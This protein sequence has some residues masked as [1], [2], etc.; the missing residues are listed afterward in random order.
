MTTLK[1]TSIKIR[2]YTLFLFGFILHSAPG[3]CQLPSFGWSR[4]GGDTTYDQGR[5]IVTDK[6]RN[7]IVT[8]MFEQHNA[9]FSGTILNASGQHDVLLLKYAPDGSLLWA[10]RAGGTDGDV[11]HA[12]AVDTSDNIFVAGEFETQSEFGSYTVDTYGSGENDGFVAKYDKYGNVMWVRQIG[13]TGDDKGYGIVTDDKGFAYTTGFMCGNVNYINQYTLSGF[14][15]EDIY[16]AGYDTYGNCAWAK[17]FGGTAN[18]RGNTI[19]YNG[20]NY[21]YVSGYFSGT[22]SFDSI[23]LTSN[24]GFDLFLAKI[25]IFTGDVQWVKNYGGASDEM[26]ARL[27][28]DNNGFIYAA[29]S[30]K[31]TFTF[32]AQTL[33]PVWN[34]DIMLLKF[35]E[36][37]VAVWAQQAGGG[38]AD[39]G[40]GVVSDDFGNVYLC[41]DYGGY[42]N[43]GNGTVLSNHGM[44]DLFIASY[45]SDG[46]LQW[47][48]GEGGSS[49][50]LARSVCVTPEGVPYA[51]GIFKDTVS[52]SGVQKITYGKEDLW[53]SKIVLPTAPVP[54]VSSS[55]L[56]V[57]PLNCDGITVN[58]T[59]GNGEKRMVIAHMDNP[60]N[61]FPQNGVTYSASDVW[62]LGSNLG[63]K[64]HVLYIGTGNSLVLTGLM[65]GMEYYF[66]VVEFNGSSLMTNYSLA[67]LP[68]ANGMMDAVELIAYSDNE[69]ICAGASTT[70]HAM[71]ASNFDWTSSTGGHYSGAD[72]V[73]SPLVSTTYK[74]VATRGMCIDSIEIMIEVN[75]VAPTVTLT[76]QDALC[77]SICTGSAEVVAT[78]TGPF[79]YDWIDMGVNTPDISG[80]CPGNYTV[81]VTDNNGCFNSATAIIAGVS[82][83]VS[84]LKTD[85]ACI[86]QCNGTATA[87]AAGSGTLSYLWSTGATT[88]GISGL[89]SGNY[90][91]TVTSTSGCQAQDQVIIQALTS[92]TAT[93]TSSEAACAGICNGTAVANISNATA[94]F[95]YA[96]SNGFAQSSQGGLCEGNYSVVI[97]DAN[98]CHASSSVSIISAPSMALN[99]SG[100][101]QAS[102]NA[103]CNGGAVASVTN[104]TSPYSYLWSSGETSPNATLLCGG[105]NIL[106]IIDANGCSVDQNFST[107]VADE[108]VAGLTVMSNISCTGMC[109]GSA[110]ATIVNGMAPYSYSWSNG[111]NQAAANQ[112]CEGNY[113]I[114]VT[115]QA[116]CS[117]TAQVNIGTNPQM[118]AAVTNVFAAS[119]NSVCNGNATVSLINGTAPFN[120][121][122]T[123]GEVSA[124]A[125]ALCSGINDVTVTD[126]SGCSVITSVNIPA[127][128]AM[129]STTVSIADNSSCNGNMCNGSGMI[130]MTNGT[131]PY[132]YLW[133]NGETSATAIGLCAGPHTVSVADANGC[134]VTA[135]LQMQNVNTLIQASIANITNAS[136]LSACNALANVIITNGTAPY[137][138]TWSNG[139][140][141]AMAIHL[142]AGTISV[143]VI[144]ALGCSSV[145]TLMI[146]SD[147]E[148]QLVASTITDAA[149]SGVCNGSASVIA[150]NGTAPFD[151]QW[152]NG[153][154]ASIVSNLCAGNYTALVT[155][156]NGC[157]AQ[158]TI[159]IN[160]GADL[161]IQVTGQSVTCD[162]SCA[163]TAMVAMLNGTFPYTIQW[164]NGLTDPTLTGLCA[165]SYTVIVT[166]A[167]GCQATQPYIISTS[168]VEVQLQ[169]DN[170]SCAG[171]CN[172]IVQA[173]ATGNAPFEYLWSMTTQQSS[174]F[175]NICS[176]SFTVQVT[177]TF[178]CITLEAFDVTEPALLSLQVS[179]IDATCIGCTDGSAT[180]TATGGTGPYTYSWSNGFTSASAL[181]LAGGNYTVCIT[182]AN[183]CSQCET[184]TILEDPT[185]VSSLAGENFIHIYPNP[186]SGDLFIDM[187]GH[188][189]R[190]IT[191]YEA[192]G[193]LIK[194]ISETGNPAKKF[195]HI[196]LNDV[197]GGIYMLQ[198]QTES[199]V[200]TIKLNVIKS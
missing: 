192:G 127:A 132:T 161:A 40:K 110:E 62:G 102:C 1:N 122:W 45:T 199:M 119:C 18:D 31:S 126:A 152:S 143:E 171:E 59:N 131:A 105:S 56:I 196:D 44:N 103:I 24:G 63:E 197:S 36:N 172:G 57:T 13:S 185:V 142:C 156:D 50:D 71:G 12:V 109:N 96:W 73:V 182:D 118:V 72:H 155:D 58:W 100:Y 169:I 165:G 123:N 23:T 76:S 112:L 29:G 113:S 106:T 67:N 198:V 89:C 99:I 16:V 195:I 168:S 4:T 77:N 33:T 157:T 162:N 64:N 74:V 15:G 129:I 32:G 78:G 194:S 148:I 21:L 83:S 179:H 90:T 136:C 133:D 97:T 125:N 140:T 22:A 53:A 25:S 61:H 20:G 60:V 181:G 130:S 186:A 116:G 42:C 104:G 34:N 41:G 187:K 159:Q 9:N 190:K 81:R 145:S 54:T 150:M 75:G 193:K 82:L 108:M 151:Y 166:D 146:A 188:S 79:F 84:A 147:P 101:T 30:F 164:S 117:A 17:C 134:Q 94:P 66:T 137:N 98:G 92:P 69:F 35:D 158:Q 121:L 175:S 14:G 93:I 7:V 86:E 2:I 43:F 124:T 135:N 70:L 144:D 183:G 160:N 141:D 8:G 85:V 163:G 167:T 39:N 28:R 191:L 154:N 51:T 139:E 37:G 173:I 55:N 111:T 87:I 114:T 46:I 120:F 6:G 115:D 153:S 180:A 178:G 176:G 19:I 26:C 200:K 3:K 107:P 177:D 149:C 184:I 5:G 65:P 38:Y 138:I 174:Q 27:H 52:F 47:A 80:L 10:R 48:M 88:A 95:T 170:A 128:P 11:G 49:D 68:V 91:V 189:I